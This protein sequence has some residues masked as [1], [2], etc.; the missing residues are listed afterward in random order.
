[1][2]TPASLFMAVGLLLSV[3][4][5]FAGERQNISESMSVRPVVATLSTDLS[6]PAQITISRDGV[7]FA[8]VTCS[9]K[10][11]EKTCSC[12][13]QCQSSDYDCRC[14]D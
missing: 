12:K 11:G 3:T 14:N 10:D 4:T 13:S 7:L 8:D 1:M 9:A 6:S 2:R 5:S